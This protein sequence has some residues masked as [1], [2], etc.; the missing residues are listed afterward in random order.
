MT[1]RILPA[2]LLA[3]GLAQP[4]LAFGGSSDAP[5]PNSEYRTALKAIK[6][7]DY[8]RAAKLLESVVSKQPDNADA[9]N[10]LGYSERRQNHFERSFA[11]YRR[12]LAIKPDHRG[13][14]EYLGELYLQT[15]DLAK[16]REHLK[17]LRTLC[18]RGCEEA[19]DL[20]E[21]VRA[22]EA[23]HPES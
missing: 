14:T 9:W 13:A 5:T 8:A 15:G 1:Y 19:E 22:Y 16:A 21:A 17:K 6:A 4:A 11:A 7:G 2:L 3:I 10:N 23:A 20:A 18:P 12:A